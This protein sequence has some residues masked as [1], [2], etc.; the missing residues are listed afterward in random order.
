MIWDRQFRLLYINALNSFQEFRRQGNY[1]TI[2]KHQLIA[3][4]QARYIRFHPTDRHVYNCLRV[5]AYGTKCELTI[6]H[7]QAQARSFFYSQSACA[8]PV[9]VNSMELCRTGKVSATEIYTTFIQLL[10]QS[11]SQSVWKT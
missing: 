8:K 7:I 10:T 1:E 6:D 3:P 5:E 4:V 2:D 11:T 9:F